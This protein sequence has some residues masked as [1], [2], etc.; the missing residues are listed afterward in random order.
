[1]TRYLALMLS[2]MVVVSQTASCAA[3]LVGVAVK[4]HRERK[5]LIDPALLNQITVGQTKEDEVTDLLGR[6]WNTSTSPQGGKQLIYRLDI[7]PTAE[8]GKETRT[9]FATI[10]FNQDGVVARIDRAGG[11]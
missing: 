9:A 1:M 6:P 8:E 10:T 11:S 5:G 7:Q 4:A 2:L 3:V